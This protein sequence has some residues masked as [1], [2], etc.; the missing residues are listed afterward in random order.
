MSR[1]EAPSKPCWL[2]RVSASEMIRAAYLARNS[3]AACGRNRPGS[4]RCGARFPG[5]RPR[6]GPAASARGDTRKISAH[7][8]QSRIQE[9]SGRALSAQSGRP[10]PE[11]DRRCCADRRLHN[12]RTAHPDGLHKSCRPRRLMSDVGGFQNLSRQLRL[13][14]SLNG[15]STKSVN[16]DSDA[17]N[18]RHS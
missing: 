10:G 16:K 14:D 5:S 1:I 13:P 15:S 3:H 7:E 2:N 18:F 11:L 9:Y 12:S 17:S 8:F 4:S 6:S